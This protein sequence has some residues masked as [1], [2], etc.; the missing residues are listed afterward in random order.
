MCPLWTCA[1]TSD[2]TRTT[3]GRLSHS[4]SRTGFSSGC[5]DGP[6]VLTD[7]QMTDSV[8]G[9]RW[10]ILSLLDGSLPK[11]IAEESS[12]ATGKTRS[13]LRP[14]LRDLVEQE[15]VVATAPPQSRNRKYLLPP[16]H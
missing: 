4:S 11:S 3:A 10:Q 16:R 6:Y 15:L 8:S 1:T 5:N 2:W 9:A 13:A 12:E 14:L 7:L